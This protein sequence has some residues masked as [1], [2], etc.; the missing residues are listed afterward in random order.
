MTPNGLIC[1]PMS[2]Y[3]SI[4]IVHLLKQFDITSPNLMHLDATRPNL[5]KLYATWDNLM[6]LDAIWRNLSQL[7][8]RS[9]AQSLCLFCCHKYKII[10]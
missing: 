9:Y 1:L 5:T 7:N 2:I 6:Q 3:G 4:A 10:L 8:F